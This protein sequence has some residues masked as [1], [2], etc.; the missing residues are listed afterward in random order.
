MHKPPTTTAND[1]SQAAFSA[2]RKPQVRQ[3]RCLRGMGAMRRGEAVD[4]GS[5]LLIDDREISVV[6]P[7]DFGW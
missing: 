4:D 6:Y 3:L 1:L 7:E 2:I 5:L